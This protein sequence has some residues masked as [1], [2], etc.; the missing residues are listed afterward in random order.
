MKYALLASG[1]FLL[2]LSFMGGIVMD[3]LPNLTTHMFQ[4]TGCCA[5]VGI[6]LIGFYLLEN[7]SD[8]ELGG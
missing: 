7:V 5:V 3:V 2:A 1:V 4:I 8:Q 6:A